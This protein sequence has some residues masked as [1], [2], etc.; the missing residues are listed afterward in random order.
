MQNPGSNAGVFVWTS[1]IS[2]VRPS[3][4][5]ARW[6]RST[7]W[8]KP[9]FAIPHGPNAAMGGSPD[10]RPGARGYKNTGKRKSLRTEKPFETRG[11]GNCDVRDI[12]CQGPSHSRAG[13]GV[14]TGIPHP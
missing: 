7:I 1:V 11:Q 3:Q 13:G 14:G 9:A 10:L 4:N 2:G 8:H 12:D 6:K 5:E